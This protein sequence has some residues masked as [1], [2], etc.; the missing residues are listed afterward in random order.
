MGGQDLRQKEPRHK[1]ETG[2]QHCRHRT[3]GIHFRAESGVADLPPEIRLRHHTENGRSRRRPPR[4]HPFRHLRRQG[5]DY[6]VRQTGDSEELTA[7]HPIQITIHTDECWVKKTAHAIVIAR[8]KV[9]CDSGWDRTNN[10]LLRRQLLYPLSY[11]AFC[12]DGQT[13]TD[14]LLLPKQACYQLHHIPL[15]FEPAKIQ[16]FSFFAMASSPI[17]LLCCNH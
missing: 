4:L 15:L 5:A 12:R 16:L 6:E 17:F 9:L 13:R 11:G 3:L 10:L 14:D 2:V 8:A 7:H 1:A